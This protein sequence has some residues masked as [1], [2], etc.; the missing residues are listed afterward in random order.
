MNKL[1]STFQSAAA[2]W[3]INE[4]LIAHTQPSQILAG[5]K[6]D[7][8]GT[9]KVDGH[10]DLPLCQPYTISFE[11]NASGGAPRAANSGIDLKN[12][13]VAETMTLIYR[14]SSARK[15]GWFRRDPTDSTKAKGFI[16]WLGLIRDAMETPTHDN[17][18]SDAGLMGTLIKPVRYSLRESETTQL[19]FSGFLEVELALHPYCR[20]E[21]SYTVPQ[22]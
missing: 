22:K 14:V 10:D 18:L 9:F 11:E 20:K 5:L 12:Q 2:A 16:E 17:E 3:V 6:Y 13:P 7:A 19:A 15:N 4:R 1:Y 8:E 21:R